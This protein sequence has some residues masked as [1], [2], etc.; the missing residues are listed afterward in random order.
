MKE[1]TPPISELEDMKL[2]DIANSYSSEWQSEAI[3]QAKLE[4]ANRKISINDQ[5]E[6]IEI[7]KTAEELR[8]KE[9]ENQ[10][11][12]NKTES[13]KLW[14]MLIIFI[15]GPIILMRPNLSK[16]S[17]S[18][19]KSEN[20]QLKFKQRIILFIL[21]LFA[22]FFYGNYSWTKQEEKRMEKVEKIDISDWEKEY[23]YD[24]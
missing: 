18:I 1:F 4:L 23:G 19:L 14:E 17:L 10:L 2:I 21:S 24:K 16:K 13:Y 11:E 7:W 22:W 8:V 9:Y 20:Y 15:F 12:L 5:S 6:I 3:R